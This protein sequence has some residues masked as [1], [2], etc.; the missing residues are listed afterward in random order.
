MLALKSSH[1]SKMGPWV[2]KLWEPS[3]Y[4]DNIAF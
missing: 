1:V 2:E 3:D 4:L